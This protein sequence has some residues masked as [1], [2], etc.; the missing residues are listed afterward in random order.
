MPRYRRHALVALVVTWR[1]TSATVYEIVC[2][3]TLQYDIVLSSSNAIKT[4]E[5]EG[6]PHRFNVKASERQPTPP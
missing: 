6:I 3:P 5:R 1:V 4:P 2:S